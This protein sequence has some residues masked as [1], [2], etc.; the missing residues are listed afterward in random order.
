MAGLEGASIPVGC[1]A[2][3]TRAKLVILLVGKELAWRFE[4]GKSAW[5]EAAAFL[6]AIMTPDYDTILAAV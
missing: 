1:T 5:R 6:F 4:A 2:L 3:E